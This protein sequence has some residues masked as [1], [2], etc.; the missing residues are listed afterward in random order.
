MKRQGSKGEW[1]MNDCMLLLL[2]LLLAGN[3]GCCGNQNNQNHPK[4]CDRQKQ[5]GC[6]HRPGKEEKCPCSE[7]RFEPRFDPMPFNDSG[8]TCGC[9]E[10]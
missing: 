7:Q 1:F 4:G 8:T 10:T 9:E 2:V 5:S 6:D 3:Y